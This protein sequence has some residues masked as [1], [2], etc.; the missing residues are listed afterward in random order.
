MTFLTKLLNRDSN[1]ILGAINQSF[2]YT[3][4]NGEGILED[5]NDIFA[6]L[7]GYKKQ[8]IIGKHHQLFVEEEF[9]KSA[10]YE[11]FWQQLRSGEIK[12]GEFLRKHKDGQDIFLRASYTPKLDRHGNISSIVKIAADITKEKEAQNRAAAIKDSIDLSYAYILFDPA[13]TI[14]D[15]NEN[16]THTM[17][18]NS[19]DEYRG[20]HHSIFVPKTYASSMEYTDFWKD[21]REGKVQRGEFERISKNG[22]K[23]WLQASYSPVLNSNGRI[24]AVVKTAFDITS[25]KKS[26]E[27][28][29]DLKN[30]IDLSFGYIQ[31]D[32]NGNILDV[33]TNFVDLLG[34]S[35]EETVGRHHSIFV[36]SS[37]A[38]SQEYKTFWEELRSNKTQ[39][40]QF[41][42]ITKDGKEVWIQAAY[43][44]IKND[45]GEVQSIIKI[46]ADVTA[47]RQATQQAKKELKNELF[48]NI[49][50]IASAVSQI[51][52]GARDQAEKIDRSSSNLEASL[53]SSETVTN[54]AH[55]IAT[56]AKSGK[57]ESEKGESLIN[58]LVDLMNG[59]TQT[60]RQTEAAM[61]KLE[62]GTN[63]I[64]SI[65]TIIQDI[66]NNTN[67]LALNASIE[68]AQA[69]DSGR[70]FSVI[71]Q[72]IRMLAENSR[73]SVKQ[74]ENQ[75]SSMIVDTKAVSSNMDDMT[76][77][78]QQSEEATQNVRAIFNE[79]LSSNDETSNLTSLI[80]TDSNDQKN[81]LQQILGT[82]EEIVVISE[83]TAAATEEVAT[84]AKSLEEKVQSF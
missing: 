54:K 60:A 61:E 1:E 16:F 44:P 51:A 43:T 33:N 84:A 20:Q 66:A 19:L 6:N 75:I 26:E 49:S 5:C 3:K 52:S 4:F 47:Q 82:T 78:V 55:D 50:E 11:N 73:D 14:L 34:Y 69:G 38:N 12:S 77:K 28:A 25:K 42:R 83:Q 70:G 35:I 74:I 32:P 21:L 18:Y 81:Q 71:A 72:E 48:S 27:L 41:R 80:V 58:G 15:A 68:A 56:A 76:Q 40:G 36:E 62:K 8:E 67:L 13:G 53:H 39:E 24:D 22:H 30:T 7:F 10:D 63:E 64:N 23:I 79:I 29:R 9:R 37:F 31:F 46:A 65:L 59:L 2:C 57:Q 45:A 17:G